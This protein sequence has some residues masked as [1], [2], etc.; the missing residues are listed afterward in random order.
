MRASHGGRPQG[1]RRVK[2]AAA[3]ALLLAAVLLLAAAAAMPGYPAGDA[4]RAA[5]AYGETARSVTA[6]YP[7]GEIR[8]G[9]IFYPGGRV[10]HEAYA[11]LMRALS[12]QGVLCLLQ[13]M[14]LD[15]AVLNMN[16]AGTLRARYAGETDTWLIG[17]HSLGGAMAA[18]FASAHAQDFD[19]VVLLGAY[20][21]ADLSASPL[22]VLSVYGSE[23]GVL[24]R[25]KYAQCMENYPQDFTEVIIG[26]GNHAGFGDYGAQK[27]DGAARISA[28]AQ[29]EAAAQAILSMLG[30][31]Q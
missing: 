24:D 25:E 2:R 29:T 11:P 21:T 27:G 7:E 17:G 8:A 19:G 18:S 1:K 9:L 6:F 22:K 23:D 12:A 30:G 16:A 4:A 10:A 15:L 28:Q 20:S 14:P 26:G 5:M 13:E 31:A 3:A